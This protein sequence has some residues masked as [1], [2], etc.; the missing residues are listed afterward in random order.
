MK[1]HRAAVIGIC[2]WAARQHADAYRKLD[3]DVAYV[4]DQKPGVR[5]IAAKYG[6]E[7][8]NDYRDLFCRDV[9]LVSVALP[10]ALHPKVCSD[11]LLNGKNVLCEKPIADTAHAVEILESAVARSGQ[12][13]MTGFCL[14]F[15]PFFIQLRALIQ[16]NR[17]GRIL[18]INVRKS[19]LCPDSG[20]R[21][22]KGGGACLIKD[23]HYLDLAL[24]LLADRPQSI[25]ALDGGRPLAGEEEDSYHLLMKFQS[26]TL[27]Q[28][29]SEWWKFP[30]SESRFEVIGT[31][32]IALIQNEQACIIS[33]NGQ[34]QLSLPQ[35][36]I[37]KSE[38]AAFTHAVENQIIPV[39]TLGDGIEAC[40]LVDAIKESMQTEQVITL[41]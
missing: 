5:D 19:S 22:Q 14:R 12:V 1:K 15:H 6:A 4:V 26:G 29:Q 27:L 31:D 34:A 37:F 41:Y 18:S 9:D 2:G 25:Y 23:V 11:L 13:F 7:A 21:L 30:H 38:V 32:K 33:E 36:D 20:W 39:I 10:P 24:W 28:L 3:I 35:S 16:E 8:L 17:L 40:K